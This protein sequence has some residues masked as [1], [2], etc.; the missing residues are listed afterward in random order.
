[1]SAFRSPHSPVG[2]LREP[3][4]AK[5]STGE[6]SGSDRSSVNP[7]V[8]GGNAG[9][10]RQGVSCHGEQEGRGCAVS[11][12]R[13]AGGARQR[14]PRR[15]CGGGGLH[16]SPGPVPELPETGE[17]HTQHVPTNPERKALRFSP[18]HSPAAGPP[19]LLRPEE[20]FPQ[21]VRRAGARPVRAAP[22]L[23][24]RIDRLAGLSRSN[25]ADV[26]PRGYA[27]A[28][29]WSQAGPGCSGC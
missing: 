17:A 9:S 13:R 15:P 6:N 27:A 2:S 12:D 3:T 23:Q 10:F 22:P 5:S 18:G 16:R 25:S 4:G 11:R 20:L 19:V 29:G 8:R 14:L 21:D 7:Q 24:H 26:Q 1:V 28:C